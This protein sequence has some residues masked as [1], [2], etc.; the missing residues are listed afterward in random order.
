MIVAI[1]HNNPMRWLL[2][3]S[4][5]IDGEMGLREVKLLNQNFLKNLATIE[6]KALYIQFSYTG[7][8][9]EPIFLEH[10]V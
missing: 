6:I 10:T 5:L 1:S 2:I 7:R 9:S 8:N 3:V 4:L